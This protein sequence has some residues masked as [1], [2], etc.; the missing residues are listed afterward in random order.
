MASYEGEKK[1]KEIG[2]SVAAYSG[3]NVQ[4]AWDESATPPPYTTRVC[5]LSIS[6][7][8]DIGIHTKNIYD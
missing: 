8:V 3:P 4:I 2:F 7:A 6:S 1:S 5:L